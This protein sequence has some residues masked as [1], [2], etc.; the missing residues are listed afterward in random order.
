VLDCGCS[1]QKGVVE[2]ILVEKNIIGKGVEDKGLQSLTEG[3]WA[4]M[5][6]IMAALFG[7]NST[8]LLKPELMKAGFLATIARLGN[9]GN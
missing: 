3:E 1:K 9:R 4:K 6:H 7:Y 8:W 5:D 2:A